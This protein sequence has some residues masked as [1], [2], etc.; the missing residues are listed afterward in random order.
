MPISPDQFE[1]HL[2]ELRRELHA[3]Q[4]RVQCLEA[5]LDIEAGSAARSPAPPAIN[6]FASNASLPA[7]AAP[8]VLPL[9][10][11]ALVGLAAA[12]L[13][14]ALAERGT[15]PLPAGVAVAILYSLAWLLLAAHTPAEER[16]P[17]AVRSTTS[18]LILMPVL[19]EAQ[20]RFHA[21]SPWVAAGVL[22]FFSAAGLAISWRKDLTTIAWI[23]TISALLTASALLVATRELLPFTVALLGLAVAVEFSA[24]L[25]HWVRE[26][27]VVALAADLSVLLLAYIATREGGIPPGYAA[28]SRNAVLAMQGALLLIYLSTT[29]VRTL[30]RGFVITPFE[31]AQTLLAFCIAMSGAIRL[32]AGSSTAVLS[33]GGFSALCGLACYLVSVA[34]LARES[35]SR[36]NFYAY[37]TFGLLLGLAGAVLLLERAPLVVVW[38]GLA[39]LFVRF[40]RLAGRMTLKWHGAVYLFA[41]LAASGLAGAT[42]SRFLFGG[43]HAKAPSLEVAAWTAAAAGLL[44]FG[45]VLHGRGLESASWNYRLLIV[46][47]AGNASWAVLG[48]LATML[49]PHG[50]GNSTA[51]FCP[52]LLTGMLTAVTAVLALAATRFRSSELAWLT[53]GFLVLATYKVV[54]YDLRQAETMAIVVSLLVYGGMLVLLPRILQK[55]GMA[56]QTAN[57]S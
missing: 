10:G 26:R 23:T 19:W 14:R 22:I 6:V 33:V 34:F 45:L 28:M 8:A 9:I 12:Y 31:I 46:V 55:R 1:N 32:A 44:A 40:G 13:L 47:V 39:I 7:D 29:I 5:E 17:A 48:V 54:V 52:A 57:A 43:V 11:Q 49:V 15:L 4:I 38:S 21:L 36:R 24:C 35:S 37:A 25:E 27:W 42:A 50:T 30:W 20:V 18:V 16:W 3:L 53:Y 51:D 41:A 56:R 2:Q